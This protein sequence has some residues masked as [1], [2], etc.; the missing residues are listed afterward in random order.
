MNQQDIHYADPPVA[1]SMGSIFCANA[2]NAG[3]CPVKLSANGFPREEPL[4]SRQ[5]RN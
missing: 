4:A 2:E 1:P 5:E 3:E